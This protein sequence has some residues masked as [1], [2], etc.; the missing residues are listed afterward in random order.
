MPHAAGEQFTRSGWIKV[1]CGEWKEE[2]RCRAKL[3]NTI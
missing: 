1:N 2:N 3:F